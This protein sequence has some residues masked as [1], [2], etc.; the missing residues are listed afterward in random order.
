MR[1]S[2]AT[3]GSHIN[4]RHRLSRLAWALVAAAIAGSVSLPPASAVARASAKTLTCRASVSNAHLSHYR[5]I[6]NTQS[7]KANSHGL[8]AISYDISDATE[9]FKVIVT[10]RVQS[11]SRS[12]R[13]QTSYIPQ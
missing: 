11:G 7:A 5:T 6:T 4:S 2:L 12:G 9:G 10:V 13:C 1:S 8:A 3:D